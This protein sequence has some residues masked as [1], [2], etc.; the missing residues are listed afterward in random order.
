MGEKRRKMCV[1]TIYARKRLME[2]KVC[3]RE[4]EQEKITSN[5]YNRIFF[6]LLEM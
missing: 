4:R 3:K 2:K 5:A 6:E 1:N